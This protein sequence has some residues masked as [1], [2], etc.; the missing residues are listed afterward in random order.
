MWLEQSLLPQLQ[1]GDVIVIDQFSPTS[2]K[3][4][5]GGKWLKNGMKQR[6]DELERF[7]DGVDAAFQQCPN[8]SA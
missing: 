7:R 3:L 6:W 1:P 5:I 8:L 4:S 2:T